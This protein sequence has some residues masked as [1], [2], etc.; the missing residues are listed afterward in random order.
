MHPPTH[1]STHAPTHA[2]WRSFSKGLP[3]IPLLPWS[4]ECASPKHNSGAVAWLIPPTCRALGDAGGWSFGGRGTRMAWSCHA[5]AWGE[6]K[7]R[8]P[9]KPSAS[10]APRRHRQESLPCATASNGRLSGCIGQG[11]VRSPA[12]GGAY[13]ALRK[14]GCVASS[15]LPFFFPL[16]SRPVLCR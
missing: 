4:S 10:I 13:A 6:T 5:A 2:I 9:T 7:Q 15:R 11:W 12:G 14:R 1:A 8:A 16:A 3:I